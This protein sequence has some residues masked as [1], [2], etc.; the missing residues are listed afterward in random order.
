MSPDLI[1]KFACVVIGALAI[2]CAVPAHASDVS[3]PITVNTTWGAADSPIH[4][5]GS[6][7]IRNGAQLTI[8]SGVEVNFLAHSSLIIEQGAIRAVGSASSPVVFGSGEPT[9]AKG[10]WGPIEFQN[11]SNDAVSVLDR[12]VIR[13]GKGISITQASPTLNRL[14]LENNLGAAITL[15]LAS[16]PAGEGLSAQGNDLNGILVPPGTI[17]G[18]VRWALVG[19][20]YVVQQGIVAVGLPPMTLDPTTLSLRE[21]QQALFT[22][23]L[24][25]PAPAGGLLVDVVSSVPGVASAPVSVTVPASMLEVTFNITAL[26]AGSSNLSVSRVG[27]GAMTAAVTVIPPIAINVAPP[28][29]IIPVGQTRTLVLEIGEP[30]PPGGVSIGL[31]SSNTSAVTVPAQVS[32]LEGASSQP[33]VVSGVAV[34]TSSVTASAAGY[35]SATALIEARAAFLSFGPLGVLAPGTSRSVAINLSE[36]APSGGLSIALSSSAPNVASLPSGVVAA[37]GESSA[38]VVVNG[39]AIGVSTLTATASNYD[40]ASET[41][42]VETTTLSF[43]PAGPVTI[44]EGTTDRFVVRLSQ[45]ARA[46]GLTVSLQTP[47]NGVLS[48]TPAD[49]QIAEGQT[50]ASS[51]VAVFANERLDGTVTAVAAGVNSALLTVVAEHRPQIRFTPASVVLGKGLRSEITLSRQRN[52][53]APFNDRDPLTLTLTS[54]DPAKLSVPPQVTIPGGSASVSVPFSAYDVSAPIEVTATASEYPAPASIQVTIVEPSIEFEDLD[55]SRGV[56]AIRDSF[57]LRLEVPGGT[58]SQVAMMDIPVVLAV[59]ESNPAGV[60]S[61]LFDAQGGGAALTRLIVRSGRDYSTESNGDTAY[62]FVGSPEI[63]GSYQISGQIAGQAA[64]LSALQ[65]VIDETPTLEFSVASVV[66][67]KGMLNSDI[68]IDRQLAGVAFSAASPVVV[69]LTLSEAGKI[70]VPQTLEIPA[71]ETY[72]EIPVVGLELTTSPVVVT[73]SAPGYAPSSTGLEFT[74]EQ[75]SIDFDCSSSPVRASGGRYQLCLSWPDGTSTIDRPVSV[76]PVEQDPP[77]IVTGLFAGPTGSALLEPLQLL[78][79]DNSLAP[80]DVCYDSYKEGPY[81]PAAFIGH[82]TGTT[83][84]YRLQVSVP[85]MGT[86]LSELIAVD[87]STPTSLSIDPP[88][89]LVGRGLQMVVGLSRDGPNLGEVTVDVESSDP[90]KVAVPSSLT[91]PDGEPFVS[92]PLSGIEFTS[93]P[94]VVTASVPGQPAI[95]GTVDVTVVEPRVEFEDLAE[96]RSVGGMRDEFSVRLS[97]PG[98]VRSENLT[99][100]LS[101]VDVTP[102]GIVPGIY[103]APTGAAEIT[104]LQIEAGQT[105]SSMVGYVGSPA[106][107]G[108]YRVRAAGIGIQAMNSAGQEAVMPTIGFEIGTA[109]VGQGLRSSVVVSRRSAFHS[110]FN[111]ENFDAPESDLTIALSCVAASICSVPATVTLPAGVAYLEVPISGH[112]IGATRLNF[113]VP[114]GHLIGN[115]SEVDVRVVRPS[116]TFATLPDHLVVGQAEP[117]QVLIEGGQKAA[118]AVSVTLTSDFPGVATITPS[119][120]IDADASVSGDASVQP[121][122][123]GYAT[124][125][126]SAPGFDPVTSAPIPVTE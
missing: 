85:G 94:V 79:G 57:R 58:T 7:Q 68:Y 10:N 95:S 4:V 29:S 11:G 116:L 55:E 24:A 84:T 119:V 20:P 93:T 109:I 33:F 92:L 102:A 59:A 1:S 38:S 13:H 65:Q 88:H 104:S 69:T 80:G 118:A 45:P 107:T 87:E 21:G 117:V 111:C 49:I 19:I 64:Q 6:V 103:A 14:V 3:G 9:P 106:A 37:A 16:S 50:A 77:G 22:L 40:P 46:G 28:S 15:D 124:F 66:V 67:A 5:V 42:T 26:A 73:A 126:A 2:A 123:S 30:A 97:V 36:P 98:V 25:K 34:G 71:G 53:G 70:G 91:F 113:S 120:F 83:G 78:A 60:V 48:V 96:C 43:D 101:L 108:S 99:V 74:V 8:E 47:A 105:S 54:A 63:A 51:L 86:W 90:L 82:L 62:A 121:L 114:P 12:V 27:L 32:V 56:G 115:P 112:E 18:S 52:S 35:S 41:L 125:T 76:Q 44:P 31:S 75:A 110:D 81:C 100:D 89:Q 61:G 39:N 122:A 23:R 72:V 17:A